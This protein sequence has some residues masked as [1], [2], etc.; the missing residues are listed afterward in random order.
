MDF[1]ISLKCLPEGN[2]NPKYTP[3]GEI[4]CFFIYF[5]AGD[6]QSVHLYC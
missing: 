4:N 2:E 6:S 3:S 1:K 5:K